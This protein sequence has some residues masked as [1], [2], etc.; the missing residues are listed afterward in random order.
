[1]LILGYLLLFWKVFG[2]KKLNYYKSAL[3]AGTAQVSHMLM[4]DF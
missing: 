4:G 1:M 3:S 2:L